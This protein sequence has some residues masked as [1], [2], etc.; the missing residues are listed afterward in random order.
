MGERNKEGGTREG[1][2]TVVNY[3]TRKLA[4]RTKGNGGL[5]GRYIRGGRGQA[6]RHS[7]R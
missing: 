4:G 2:G 6:G 3:N 7:V 5:G 1:R